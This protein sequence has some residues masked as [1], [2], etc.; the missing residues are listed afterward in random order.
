MS[1]LIGWKPRFLDIRVASYRLR[2][3]NPLTVLRN[4]GLPVE[5]FRHEHSKAYRAIV[6]SKLYG[7]ETYEEAQS[8]KQTG[9]RIGFDLC[10]N[11]FYSAWNSPTS[12]QLGDDVRRMIEVADGVAASSQEL[13]GEMMR[14]ATVK[15]P[16][17][18]IGDGVESEIDVSDFSPW[19][20][21]WHRLFSKHL[22]RQIESMKAKG[23]IPLVWFGNHGSPETE[24]GMLDLLKIRA[25]LESIGRR[26]PI[27][28]TVVSNAR[29][30][31]RRQIQPWALPTTYVEW[32]PIS[33]LP[34]L[35]AHSI[36]VIPI[37][38][39][40]FTRCKTSNRLAL[41]IHCGLAMVA[42]SIP[43]FRDFS[44]SCFLD[45][46]ND[47]LLAYL[48]NPGLRQRHLEAGRA[49]IE[50]SFTGEK[51]ADQWELFFQNLLR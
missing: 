10:D 3:L 35:R 26:F 27:S 8:L 14:Q 23:T 36:A 43:S 40:P 37:T 22:L 31:F 33:F 46:W 17:T 16:I 32:S 2:C 42:D 48:Q 28:L 19:Q 7:R 12:R 47:G 39:N 41:A 50:K 5:L 34:I 45:N 25:V 9:V 51:I 49:V 13:A 24:G 44:E 21:A 15:K 1:H 30:K 4:R 29:D 20:R 18:V 6:Y 11:H 38:A